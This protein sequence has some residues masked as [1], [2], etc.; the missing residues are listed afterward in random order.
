[1]AATIAV[2]GAGRVG[3]TLAR[4]LRRRGYHTGLVVTTRESTARAA[5]LFI[6]AGT[7]A[8]GVGPALAQADLVLITTPDRE[9][10]KVARELA[11][12][13]TSWRGRVVL[14]TSGALSSREL[15]PLRAHGAAVGSCHPIYPFPRPLRRFPRGVVFDVEGGRRA[16]K[17]ATALA[18]ALGGIPVQLSARGK[19]LCHTVGTL[20]A[21]HLLMLVDLGTRGLVRAGVPRRLAWPALQPLVRETLRGYKRWGA[22]A[23]TGPLQRGDV[24]TVRRHLAVLRALPYPYLEV[25]L[26]LARASVALYRRRPDKPTRELR[27]LLGMRGRVR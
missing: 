16:V 2:V 9:V 7:S 15:A 14:H 17:V 10:A 18:R 27:R 20:A 25:Y 22:A 6:G 23:W 11:R 5:V 21:G 8:V 12:L 26:A 13:P 24:G 3:Q 1:M 4:S 19:T